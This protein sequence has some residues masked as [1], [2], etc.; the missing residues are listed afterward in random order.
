[1][2]IVMNEAKDLMDGVVLLFV[3]ESERKSQQYF[4][5]NARFAMTSY[6]AVPPPFSSG[7]LATIGT[8]GIELPWD[9][10]IQ[11]FQ[12]SGDKDWLNISV[13]INVLEQTGYG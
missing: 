6:R 1:M 10:L 9:N 12:L 5:D 13:K 7:C 2:L 11:D 4:F 3:V 8:I